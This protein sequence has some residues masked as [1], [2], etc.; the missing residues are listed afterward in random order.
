MNHIHFNIFLIVILL[1]NLSIFPVIAV[2]PFNSQTS[3]FSEGYVIE[4]PSIETIKTG[5]TTKFNFH[6]FNISNGKDIISGIS[7]YYHLYNSS[8]SHIY[9]SN[10]ST[11]VNHQFDYEVE[12]AGSNFTRE[13][14][15][16]YI[17]Q[18]NSSLLGGYISEP[19]SVT[20]TGQQVSLSNII[21]V[22]A[23]L[24]ISGILFFISYSF[25]KGEIMMKSAFYLFS[26]MMLLIAL[27]SGRIIADESMDLNIMS[28][29]GLILLISIT[30]FFFLYVFI[31]WTIKTFELFKTKR[32]MR[33]EY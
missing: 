26:L 23:F 15:Y 31:K 9:E 3:P 1:V 7:C 17:F 13:G 24:F 5:V 33:W 18:C 20:T 14:N 21:L 28:N 29:S 10:V 22:I 30:L 27:N 32:G 4:Y 12:V 11:N 19:V 8:G 2:S 6:V 16:F 25:D